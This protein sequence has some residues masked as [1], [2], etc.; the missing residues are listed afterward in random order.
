MRNEHFNTFVELISNQ[1]TYGGQ[2]YAAT[3]T[4]EA[5]DILVDDFG[6]RW[7]LGT[8]AKYT[9]RFANLARERDLLKIACYSKDTEVLTEDG[10]KLIKDIVDKGEAVKVAT[11]NPITKQVEYCYPSNY[12]KQH[13]NETLFHQKND[14]VDLLVTNDHSLYIKYPKNDYKLI[15]AQQANKIC[16]Y[17]RD[18]PYENTKKVFEYH[19]IEKYVNISY[20]GKYKVTREIEEKHIKINDWLKFLGIFLAEGYTGQGKHNKSI[21]GVSQSKKANPKK[22]LRI[23]KLLDRLPYSYNMLNDKM[24]FAIYDMQLWEHLSV[25]GKCRDKHIPREFLKYL[26]KRQC[27]ILLKWLIMGDGHKRGYNSYS[28]ATVSKQLANDVSELALKAGFTSKVSYQNSSTKD[29]Y[30]IS[31]SKKY[32]ECIVNSKKDYRAQIKYNDYV[33]CLE[34]PNHIMYVRRNGKSIW[35]GNCYMFILWLKRGFHLSKYG[36]KEIIDTTVEVKTAHFEEFIDRVKMFYISYGNTKGNIHS[37]Y[38]KLAML[39]CEECMFLDI[40]EIILLNIFISTYMIWNNEIPEE[41]KTKDED[42]YNETR[43]RN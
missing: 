23:K 43:T 42:V 40:K 21:V 27:N 12:I 22:Y 6:Y 35:C 30:T 13:R 1:F 41:L 10:W 33:Y 29:I 3:T 2:K 7:L 24:G 37:I 17:K 39:S 16:Y 34:V 20:E 14:Y 32:K 19:M 38:T 8:V 4:K 18:F 36:S 5:T 28:Y 11:L 9:K 26:T 25:F 15:P 31:I